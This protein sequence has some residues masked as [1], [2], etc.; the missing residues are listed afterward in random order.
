MTPPSDSPPDFYGR[1][2]SSTVRVVTWN[3]WGRHSN[4]RG[5]EPA[6]IA[7]LR[8][9]RPDVLVL[10]ESWATNDDSQRARLA[11]VLRMPHHTYSGV[12]AEEDDT[13]LSGVAVMSR[14]PIARTD[15]LTFGGARVELAE[16]TGPRGLV[17]VAGVVMDAWWFDES[18][19]RQDAVRGL[20]EHLAE[21]VDD[22]VPLV[23]C[24]DFNCDPDSDEIRMLTG[25]C[26]VP[27][28]GM[29]FYD[30]WEVAGGRDGTDPTG[31]TWS[32][33]NP[34]TAPLL[35]PDRRIDYVFSATRRRGGAGHPV[36]AQL[37]GTEPVDGVWPSDHSAVL[38]DL[39][40]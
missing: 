31:A 16:I 39:R 30:A 5:R 11:G 20:L 40:Y 19:A 3:V 33:A 17:Q 13:A 7:T 35:W 12:Q 26:A 22:A 14:W 18:Q 25:R 32:R 24:G 10:A 2:I 23:V 21:L 4:W 1:L 6:I 38:A 37:L 8:G 9:A 29:S 34:C 28:P 27:V 36:R 15:S